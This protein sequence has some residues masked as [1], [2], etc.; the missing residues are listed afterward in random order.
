MVGVQRG[1]Q[2]EA[3]EG[4]MNEELGFPPVGSLHEASGRTRE[5]FR[6]LFQ[7]HRRGPSSSS[8]PGEDDVSL[9]SGSTPASPFTTTT[10]L[11]LGAGYLSNSSYT[12]SSSMPPTPT[13][14]SFVASTPPPISSPASTRDLYSGIVAS[15]PSPGAIPLASMHIASRFNTPKTG[16]ANLP[17][18]DDDLQSQG[19]EPVTMR[20]SLVR[21]EVDS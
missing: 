8:A 5:D 3:G 2:D 6:A 19:D 1:A 7:R 11:S 15:A 18:D 10:S 21:M 16:A 17:P 20:A 9:F 12:A 14:V 13:G 4:T